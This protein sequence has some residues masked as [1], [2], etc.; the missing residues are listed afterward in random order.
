MPLHALSTASPLRRRLVLAASL[1][2]PAILLQ[3]RT[4]WAQTRVPLVRTPSQT[5]GPFYPV[6]EPADSDSD[7]LRNGDLSYTNGQ[8]CW[9]EGA[10]LDLEG[11][12][13]SGAES[14]A[15]S[16]RS[17][18][19]ILT[20]V[21]SAAWAMGTLG[22][23]RRSRRSRGSM[24]VGHVAKRAAMGRGYYGLGSGRRQRLI[25]ISPDF[26]QPEGSSA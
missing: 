16:G 6:I 20:R 18:P 11:R 15:R 24:S 5:E 25:P 7:L 3:N 21:P 1:G 22:A 26:D 14:G 2:A 10:V 12:P 13:V 19:V 4:G 23:D 8:P 17:Q 9:L